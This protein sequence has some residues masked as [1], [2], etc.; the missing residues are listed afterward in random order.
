[1]DLDVCDFPCDL[2]IYLSTKAQKLHGFA[3]C[4]NFFTYFEKFFAHIVEF[5]QKEGLAE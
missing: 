5:F 3:P 4:L 1:M 2:P